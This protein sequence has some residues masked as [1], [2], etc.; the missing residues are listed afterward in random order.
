[1]QLLDEQDTG[2]FGAFF[3]HPNGGGASRSMVERIL[4]EFSLDYNHFREVL[5]AI[6]VKPSEY[7]TK[8]KPRMDGK[9]L[10]RGWSYEPYYP[11]SAGY[12]ADYGREIKG[13][14]IYVEVELSDVRRAVNAMFMSRVFRAGYMRLGI[15]IAPES[16]SPEKNKNFYSALKTRYDYIAPE[17]PLWLI[18]FS[19]P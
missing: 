4:K 14:H 16:T 2:A 7:V 17:Y 19:Y 1:M 11:E 5:L 6:E 9:F 15:Y 8:I 12:Q 10:E 13:R 18:G 3:G